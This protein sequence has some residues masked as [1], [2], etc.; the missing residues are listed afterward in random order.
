MKTK[1]RQNFWEKYK[2]EDLYDEEWE[3]LCDRCGK[4]CLIKIDNGEDRPVT[5]TK[6]ACRL[7]DDKSC[8]CT[9][10]SKRKK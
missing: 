2:L 8:K 7:F 1:V 9:K 4:C 6:A 3:L 10:Y 5:Y